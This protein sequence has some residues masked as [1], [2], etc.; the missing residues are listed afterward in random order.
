MYNLLL[1]VA[2]TA[3]AL[4]EIDIPREELMNFGTWFRGGEATF[5]TMAAQLGLAVLNFTV[6]LWVAKWIYSILIELTNKKG[7]HR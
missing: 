7:G 2:S 6:L 3:E 4:P 1:S 5:G